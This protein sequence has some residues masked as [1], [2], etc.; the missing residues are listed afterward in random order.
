MR[1]LKALFAAAVPALAAAAG[2][3]WFL[4]PPS[5]GDVMLDPN[6]IPTSPLDSISAADREA[7]GRRR[8][9]F[10]HKSVGNDVL[11][12]VRGLLSERKDLPLSIRSGLSGPAGAPGLCESTVGE[13]RDPLAKIRDFAANL[14]AAGPGAV[15]VAVLKFCFVDVTASTDTAA[16]FAAYEEAISSLRKELPGTVFVHSTV[17]L[18]ALGNTFKARVK[19]ILGRDRDP[20]DNARREEFNAR[21]R[22]AFAGREP[23]FDIARAEST[24]P[25]GE[26]VTCRAMGRDVPCMARGYTTDGGHLNAAG[27]RAAA[28]EFLRALAESK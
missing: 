18:T 16:L 22:S 21:I 20:A 26:R 23:I 5:P 24:L 6:D 11:D 7:L 12:G 9:Y 25:D 4:A 2:A 19:R 15:D 13:N 8:I 27:K 28:V 3:I 1:L 17:P 10:G 14:R